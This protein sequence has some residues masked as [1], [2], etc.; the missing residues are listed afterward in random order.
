M[1]NKILTGIGTLLLAASFSACADWVDVTP[2]NE[3]ESKKLFNSEQGFKSALI[4]IYAR[5]TLTDTYGKAMTYGSI[6]ELAQRYDNYGTNVP[7]DAERAQR[8]DYRNNTSAKSMVNSLW[9]NLYRTIANVNNLIVKLDET[10]K[11]IVQTDGYWEMM[12]GEA[13]G[14]RA[15][16][17]FD[18][19]RL[20]GPVY[21]ENPNMECL[22]WRT[23]FDS[24]PKK[25]QSA[26]VIIDHILD[27]LREAEE[28]LKDDNL[29]YEA[30]LSEPFIGL[31]K[32]RMNL[33]AVKALMARVYLWKG[34]KENARLKAQEVIEKCGLTLVLNNTRDVSM[35][36]ETIFCL[37]MDDMEE[38]LKSDW[39]NLT[40][41]S[42]ELYI[43]L[44]NADNVFNV[45]RGIAVNDIRYRNGYGFIHGVS[46]QLLCRKYL[47]ED[48]Q[49]E[50]KV[51]LIRLVEMYYI[52]AESLPDAEK[53][54]AVGYLNTVRNARGIPSS[55]N[56]GINDDLTEEL[57]KEYQK[58]FFAEGQWFYF[59]KRH[60]CTTFYRCPVN[61]M[62]SYYVLPTPDDESEYGAG[63]ED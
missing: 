18:L 23:Q 34:D 29:N 33:M 27:D 15:F 50:E 26:S 24:T 7:T 10:G 8:Y 1:K 28:L 25:L 2:K 20:Y 35:Y 3:V 51:P 6:E 58:E 11:S 14:L 39:A 32:H 62:T 31:R 9:T 22:P 52:L 43:S 61:N 5:M 36:G 40:A 41:F 56:I 54:T 30:N 57:N 53:Q 42:N 16:H 13:L 49:Y 12:K 21:S 48:V 37:G 47:G 4:G 46:N 44:N 63:A 19:L 55:Y 38:K 59:L 45:P 17:Y 60:N